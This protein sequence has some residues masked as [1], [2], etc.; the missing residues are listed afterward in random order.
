MTTPICLY[1]AAYPSIPCAYHPTDTPPEPTA[2]ERIRPL[3]ESG[4]IQVCR[5]SKP[6]TEHDARLLLEFH[7]HLSK[8]PANNPLE[9][10]R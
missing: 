2:L 7:D 1:C 8:Q 5:S 4:A 9:E 6:L 3:I 10:N